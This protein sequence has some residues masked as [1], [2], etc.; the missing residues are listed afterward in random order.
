MV[1]AAPTVIGSPDC[2]TGV[3][4]RAH[5][6]RLLDGTSTATRVRDGQDAQAGAAPASAASRPPWAALDVSIQRRGNVVE[7]SL[8]GHLDVA[9]ALRLGEAMT[10][11]RDMATPR[12]PSEP[13]GSRRRGRGHEATIVI[14]TS[15]L[16]RVD[17]AGYQAL[18]AA[19]LGPNGLWDPGVAW[20]VG[21]AVATLEASV[22][23][24]GHEGSAL[25]Q[26]A[27]FQE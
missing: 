23:S 22:Y 26:L 10:L 4:I 17:A 21:P 7:L 14:D 19:L 2:S 15:D 9:T 25:S 1:S 24:A 11:A 3:R 5:G 18:Q 16:D 27:S 20:I 6:Q 13:T 12:C 8:T